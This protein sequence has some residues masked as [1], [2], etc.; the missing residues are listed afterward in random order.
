MASRTANAY[1]GSP[2]R[3]RIIWRMRKTPQ[4]N[5]CKQSA[6]KGSERL[7]SSASLTP[8]KV[9]VH[10]LTPAIRKQL[11]NTPPAKAYDRDGARDV[12]LSII[13][14][15]ADAKAVKVYKDRERYDNLGDYLDEM[16]GDL[17]ARAGE[18]LVQAA[19]GERWSRIGG[20]RAFMALQWLGCQYPVIALAMAKAEVLRTRSRAERALERLEAVA[21]EAE[22]D[23]ARVKACEVLLRASHPAFGAATE[24]KTGSDRPIINVNLAAFFGEN[25]EKSVKKSAGSA[26]VVD[27]S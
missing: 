22:Q 12:I 27:I 23:N 2:A 16:E 18:W 4:S 21:D 24:A 9:K 10:H 11:D 15:G 17:V 25:G 3:G 19:A 26:E 20:G 1:C 6:E 5:K 13:L 14:A 8:A 7:A